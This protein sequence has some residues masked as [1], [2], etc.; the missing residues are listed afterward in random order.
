[1]TNRVCSHVI[2]M[3]T[4]RWLTDDQRHE[5]LMLVHHTLG[6]ARGYVHIEYLPASFPLDR[7]TMLRITYRI[8]NER[9]V[10]L[11]DPSCTCG[12]GGRPIHLWELT[13]D[14]PLTEP[15][16]AWW[17]PTIGANA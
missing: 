9:R 1:M 8:R 6:L 7:P 2:D 12:E 11:L 5:L 17:H 14:R 13:V 10:S 15:L 3:N 16:P 4:F